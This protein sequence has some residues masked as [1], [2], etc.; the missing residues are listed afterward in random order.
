[1]GRWQRKLKLSPE[2]NEALVGTRS[3]QSLSAIIAE[4]ID[5]LV[6]FGDADLDGERKEIAVD[7]R[8]IAA[9]EA[10]TT[11]DFDGV[12][13]RLYDWADTPLD[14]CWNGKKA[15]WVDR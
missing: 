1:M 5:R 15:C 13:E 4:R 9:D 2:W 12:M 11:N 6:P 7:F 8:E 3:I 14:A 10:A